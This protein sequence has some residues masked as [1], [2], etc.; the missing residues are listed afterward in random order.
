[1]TWSELARLG[2]GRVD[3]VGAPIPISPDG[4]VEA[5][6]HEPGRLGVVGG[7]ELA[8]E[9]PSQP[10]AQEQNRG[11]VHVAVHAGL[12]DALIADL[13]ECGREKRA[14]AGEAGPGE[15]RVA[16]AV[17]VGQ[18]A[19]DERRGCEAP[20]VSVMRRWAIAP[21][22]T[23]EGTRGTTDG[24]HATMGASGSS[25]GVMRVSA[26]SMA[27]TRRPQQDDLGGA[28]VAA[29][30][31]LRVERVPSPLAATSTMM[32]QGCSRDATLAV[33][34]ASSASASVASMT[35]VMTRPNVMTPPSL[36]R[37]AAIPS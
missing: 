7:L 20:L 11:R 36:R 23:A 22:P 15:I 34:I 21:R 27:A 28:G 37:L 13:F 6:G 35:R 30:A 24:H 33:L 4:R 31:D 5:D 29:H 16:G 8:A 9:G 10:G 19:Q 17:A 2:E 1:M 26:W 12:G 32:R 18:R 14:P 25:R 3:T